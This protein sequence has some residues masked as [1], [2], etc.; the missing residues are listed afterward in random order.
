MGYTVNGLIFGERY[1]PA[2]T[3]NVFLRAQSAEFP[4]WISPP[5]PS[6]VFYHVRTHGRAPDLPD[7]HP[8]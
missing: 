7:P 2:G 6:L 8:A 5:D 3:M 1:W 4:V